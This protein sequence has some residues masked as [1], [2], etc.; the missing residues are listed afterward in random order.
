MNDAK[1]TSLLIV[2]IHQSS[3][4]YPNTLYRVRA[5]R[6]YF[7]ADEIDE[8]LWT[9]P[10]GGWTS[11]KSPLRALWRALVSH[12]RVVMSVVRKGGHDVAYVPYPAPTVV[13]LL[14]LLPQRLR[15]RRLVLDGFISIYDTVVNDRKVWHRRSVPGRVLYALERRAFLRADAVLVDTPQ[16]ADFY[17]GMFRLPRSRFVPLPLATNEVDFAERPYVPTAG[18]CRVLFIGTLVPLHGIGTIV[19]AAKLLSLRSDIEFRILG[20][21][22]DG[23]AIQDE[24]RGLGNVVWQRRWHSSKELGQ[25]IDGADICLGIF[26]DSDKAQRVCPYKLYAYA[27]V[28]RAT[29]TGST[30]WLRSADQGHE[31][32]FMGVSVSNPSELAGA[33]ERLADDVPLRMSYARCAQAFYRDRLSNARALDSLK[34]RIDSLV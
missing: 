23:M 2:G 32:A 30:D 19:E 16:N 1:R 22:A 29:I 33:I 25:E 3:E 31:K 26:G 7:G 4:A 10:T 18:R 6:E 9:T 21:G 8:P 5:L 13:L 27:S 28:G 14:S 34:E 24:V 17:A 11:T 12:L 20:D 15:P